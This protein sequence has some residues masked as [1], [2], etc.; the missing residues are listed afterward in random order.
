M[1]VLQHFSQTRFMGYVPEIRKNLSEWYIVEVN[2]TQKT[3]HNAGYIALKLK[4]YFD[5]KNGVIFICDSKN[6]LVL[7]HM[8]KTATE[9][10]LSQGIIKK[11][12]EHSCTTQAAEL[13]SE[14]FTKIRIQ[15]DELENG[16]EENAHLA[17]LI[18]TRKNRP[19]C[20]VMVVDDD[21]LM[22]ALISETF[23]SRS[24]IYEFKDTAKVLETYLEVLPDIVF[25][26]IHLPHGSGMD[27]L[28]EIRKFDDS[29]HI[30]IL[31]ADSVKDNIVFARELG[32]KGFIAKPFT[33]EKLES[34][35]KKCPTISKRQL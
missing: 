35:Y 7:A 20:L 6:V 10:S 19:Q 21:A 25:L 2:L 5:D 14:G 27:L 12:P 3:D 26:D 30:I 32:A 28:A 8:G 24:R 31:S 1:D 4:E 23:H 29:A 34:C 13:T 15:L 16:K 18:A 33:M 22:R 17:T 11:L 9:K